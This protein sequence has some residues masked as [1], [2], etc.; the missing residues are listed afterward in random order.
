MENM[1]L[2]DQVKVKVE[3]K[4]RYNTQAEEI[5]GFLKLQPNKAG[6]V[7]QRKI[8]VATNKRKTPLFFAAIQHYNLKTLAIT[9]W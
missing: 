6:E 9:M 1:R 3:C 5:N 8:F 4:P 2:V 7:A